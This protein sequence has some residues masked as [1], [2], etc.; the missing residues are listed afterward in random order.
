MDE[1]Q[2]DLTKELKP[3]NLE[4]IYQC[5]CNKKKTQLDFW[6]YVNK[7]AIILFCINLLMLT[8]I[9]LFGYNTS[10]KL[11]LSFP[12]ILSAIYSLMVF[13]PREFH[14]SPNINGLLNGYLNKKRDVT[15][16]QLCSN[17]AD[18]YEKTS[19]SLRAKQEFFKFSCLF[20][21]AY[22]AFLLWFAII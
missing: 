2:T 3:D 17:I 18:D 6:E 12:L 8:S 14:N 9:I 11:I 5:I 21:V 16:L 19:K 13:F 20:L 1:E 10:I 4:L 7:K 15:V 22:I